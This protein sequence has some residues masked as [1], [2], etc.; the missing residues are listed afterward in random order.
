MDIGTVIGTANTARKLGSASN[1]AMKIVEAIRARRYKSFLAGVA[2]DDLAAEATLLEELED[3]AKR[4][5]TF[6][7]VEEAL[8]C[9]SSIAPF[10]LGRLYSATRRSHGRFGSYDATKALRALRDLDDVEARLLI[11]SVEVLKNT[12]SRVKQGMNDAE[13]VPVD[14]PLKKLWAA[15]PDRRFLPDSIKTEQ[16]LAEVLDRLTGLGL[17]RAA[18]GLMDT[19]E[20][21]VVVTG[22]THKV[23]EILIWAAD[24]AGY[25]VPKAAST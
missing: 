24:K 9:G 3:P 5:W 12:E 21:T 15:D 16:D 11:L 8:R 4:D 19:T 25:E 20:F 1:Q 6:K 10:A 14:I 7:F 23:C 22:F 2:D 17:F 18:Q 13:S